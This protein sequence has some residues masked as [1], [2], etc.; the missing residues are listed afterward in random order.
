VSE[1][2]EHL[3]SALERLGRAGVI[4]LALAI[5]ALAFY[6]SAVTPAERELADLRAE[7]E[8]LQQRLQTGDL[9]AGGAKGT[10]AEQL[11]TFYAFFPRAQSSPDW[12]GKIHAAARAKGLVLRSGEYKL[13]RS[14]DPR[15]ARYQITLP[16]VGSYAQIRGFVGQ[17]LADVPAAALEEITLRRESVATPTL[18]ARIRLTLY[19]GSA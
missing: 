2:R 18:E 3:R 9:A 17:V 10:P 15:L 4:G 7:A 1:L 5:F 13:E 16:V 11:A 6:F 8:R 12:L 19:L 14:V